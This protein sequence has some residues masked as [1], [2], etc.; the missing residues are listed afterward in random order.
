[1]LEAPHRV[2]LDKLLEDEEVLRLLVALEVQPRQALV[3]MALQTL[4]LVLL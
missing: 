1:M 3:A 2:L 4:Y